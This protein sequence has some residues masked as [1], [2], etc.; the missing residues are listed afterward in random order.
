MVA[1]LV[2]FSLA[3]IIEE[4]KIKNKLL[5]ESKRLTAEIKKHN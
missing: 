3:L 2:G 5:K 4:I 1:Y